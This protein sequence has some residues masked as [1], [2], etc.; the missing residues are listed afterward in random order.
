MAQLPEKDLFLQEAQT[1]LIVIVPQAQQKF[2]DLLMKLLQ[3]QKE[4]VL[5]R[6]SWWRS[7]ITEKMFHRTAV[8]FDNNRYTW[9]VEDDSTESLIR[10][11]AIS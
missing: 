8:D 5:S 4:N 1:N 3:T 9:A 2:V 10:L 11:T 7:N 6:Y